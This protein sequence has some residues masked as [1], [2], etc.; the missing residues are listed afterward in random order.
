MAGPMYSADNSLWIVTGD[1]YRQEYYAAVGALIP[2]P[3]NT[4]G[5]GWVQRYW[6]DSYTY[7]YASVPSRID[8]S[9]WGVEAMLGY[10]ASRPGLAGAAYL[11]V[12]Y[13]DTSLNPA[14]PSNA[15]AG[16]QLYLKGQ[17]EGEVG[18]AQHW[19]A[20]GIAAYTFGENGYWVRARVLRNLKGTKFIG[21]EFIV[22]GDPTYTAQKIGVV[23]GGL[24]PF[25]GVFLNLKAGYRFQS[26]ADSPY[27][28]VEVIGQF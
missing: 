16:D 28:G 5:R 6:I 23:Y 4:L 2:L 20:N 24:Q 25:A 3:G 19:R 17:L 7:S 1:V 15:A 12:R 10:Q 8:A 9:V 13:Q 18:F 21:P 11:G 14:D 22:Q 26:G 27:I